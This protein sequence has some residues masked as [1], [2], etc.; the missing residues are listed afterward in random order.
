M[1]GERHGRP[2]GQV[3]VVWAVP[4]PGIGNLHTR[5]IKSY[6]FYESLTL[7]CLSVWDKLKLWDNL[8]NNKPVNFRIMEILVS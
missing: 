4:D 7:A 5:N 8:Q 2:L 1:T 6:I 3:R